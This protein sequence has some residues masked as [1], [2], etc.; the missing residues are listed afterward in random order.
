M[1]RTCIIINMRSTRMNDMRTEIQKRAAK[2]HTR[3]YWGFSRYLERIKDQQAMSIAYLM[4][5]IDESV[6]ND[7][8]AVDQLSIHHVFASNCEYSSRGSEVGRASQLKNC[9]NLVQ[10]MLWVQ[11][12]LH[13][14]P[15]PCHCIHISIVVI[16]LF[17]NR[18]VD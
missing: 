16:E 11:S 6:S 12:I 10:C 5:I 15:R 17:L 7:V 13:H 8:S 2:V 14:C 3:S 4:N 1:F 18:L 9:S